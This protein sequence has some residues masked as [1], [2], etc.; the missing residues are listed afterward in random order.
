MKL[1]TI[2]HDALIQELIAG[3]R[4]ELTIILLT[5]NP[6]H[7]QER[8]RIRFGAIENY[9]TI[10]KIL[11]GIQ[12]E[13]DDGGYV[14]RVDQ[15]QVLNEDAPAKDLMEVAIQIDHWERLVLRCRKISISKES[16]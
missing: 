2:F 14:G 11:E 8:Y 3:P 7:P 15:M 16:S 12:V 10:V 4:K 1:P 5:V 6:P 9:A 13:S